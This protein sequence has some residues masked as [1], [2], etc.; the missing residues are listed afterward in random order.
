MKKSPWVDYPYICLIWATVA[1]VFGLTSSLVH[2]AP[3]VPSQ[4]SEVLERLP[5]RPG[6][7]VARDLAALRAEVRQAAAANPR[8]PLPATRL[9]E[10]YFDL[11]MA[12]GDPRYVGYADAVL[13]PFGDV[14]SAPLWALRG[15]LQQYRHGFAPAL[16]NFATALKIDPQFASAHAWRGA[17]YLVQ[18]DYPAARVECDALKALGRLALRGA[19]MGL[20]AA[21]TGQLDAALGYLQ[22]ANALSAEPENRL[23]LDTRVGEV[24]AWHGQAALAEAAYR[25]ALALNLDDGYLLAAWS[26]FLLDQQRP[27]E[28]VKALAAWEA[29]DTLLL[30][31]AL[32]ETQLGLP[33]ARAH[34]QALEDRFAAARQ[35]GDTT[36][37]AEEARFLLQLKGDVAQALQVALANYQVQR[38]P[39]DARI[40]LEAAL[41]ANAPAAAQPVQDW[42][43]RS[44]FEDTRLRTLAATLTKA[45]P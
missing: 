10:R 15:Q 30:R 11:A 45:A 8:D 17:I 4:A 21:Y 22:E 25:R 20:V 27:A 34:T 7:T 32:A 1:V 29:S 33:K 39:R 24:Q 18:A 9:A 28:V 19:C 31:L 3:R 37:R 6:D 44:G 43:A 23:W 36:H 26:D 2:A 38:E 13:Q 14:Q 40:V 41:A 5:M 12:R 35:R 42:L 16:D